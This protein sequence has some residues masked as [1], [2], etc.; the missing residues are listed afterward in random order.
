MLKIYMFAFKLSDV[1]FIMLINIKMPTVV[2][3]GGILHSAPLG[4]FCITFDLQRVAFCN[5]FH[6]H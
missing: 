4:A 3:K 1:V 6:L 5:T 2:D